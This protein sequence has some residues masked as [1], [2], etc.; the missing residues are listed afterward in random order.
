MAKTKKQ[1]DLEAQVASPSPTPAKAKWYRVL[2][3][4]FIGDALRREGEY[5]QY[6]GEPGRNLEPASIED[7]RKAGIEANEPTEAELDNF[8]ANLIER[9]SDL[10]DREKQVE[11]RAQELDKLIQLQDDRAKELDQ[12]EADLNAREEAVKEKETPA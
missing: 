4:S 7:V 9:E 2:E 6:D 8:Q 12:R 3:E 1:D 10:A 11:T 5:V